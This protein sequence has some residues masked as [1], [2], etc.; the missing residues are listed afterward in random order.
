M[1]FS[2]QSASVPQPVVDHG[3]CQCL[4][5]C[6]LQPCCRLGRVA[7]LLCLLWLLAVS[8]DPLPLARVRALLLGATA[9]AG[10]AH[11]LLLAR[12]QLHGGAVR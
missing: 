3:S 9:V 6:L 1:P 2:A 11:V 5:A 7:Q 10:A 8:V 12:A 4:V